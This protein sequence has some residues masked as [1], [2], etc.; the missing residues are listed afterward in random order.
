M[1]N[2]RVLA[3]AVRCALTNMTNDRYIGKPTDGLLAQAVARK[4]ADAIETMSADTRIDV[5]S[6]VLIDTTVHM[7]FKVYPPAMIEMLIILG[8]EYSTEEEMLNE[9][10]PNHSAP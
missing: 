5:T 6:A 7:T 1:L 3:P 10:C 4:V 9:G 8:P 2:G